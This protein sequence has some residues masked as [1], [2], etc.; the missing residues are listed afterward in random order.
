VS[1]YSRN[2]ASGHPYGKSHGSRYVG[3]NTDTKWQDYAGPRQDRPKD[4]MP[5]ALPEVYVPRMSKAKSQG[6]DLA[7]F[8]FG[9]V[10]EPEGP[11]AGSDAADSEGHAVR[12][13]V[14]VSD[15][16]VGV[17]DLVKDVYWYPDVDGDALL[18]GA[19]PSK[20][21]M[22]YFDLG[23]VVSRHVEIQ[24][25]NGLL[26]FDFAQFYAGPFRGRKFYFH[27]DWKRCVD[28]Y[29]DP[30]SRVNFWAAAQG[31]QVGTRQ[32]H[33]EA[34]RPG[35]SARFEVRFRRLPEKCVRLL[36]EALA[37]SS[38]IRHKLGGLKPFGFGS[39]CLR[40]SGLRLYRVQNGCLA[41]D[42]QREGE[43]R[44]ALGAE[45]S[46]FEAGVWSRAATWAWACDE[47]AFSCSDFRLRY[48]L[49]YP[50][51]IEKAPIFCYPAYLQDRGAGALKRGFAVPNAASV[52]GGSAAIGQHRPARIDDVLAYFDLPERDRNRKITQHLGLL[53]R[54]SRFFPAVCRRALRGEEELADMT[55]FIHWDAKGPTD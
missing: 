50:G 38:G 1:S 15:S 43:M 17:D 32:R 22:M 33:V 28:S 37:P 7:T 19:A 16:R 49:S 2:D 31:N 3:F 40:P 12:S 48:L 29:R 24:G 8:L 47:D 13:R 5:Q 35:A 11:E 4:E 14:V 10:L 52:L 26:K 23:D 27:Q 53:Q 9:A 25:R 55:D 21:S 34:M 44:E 54:R 36:V 6:I 39:I 41:R 51:E 30:Q 46:G 42:S 45:L 20:S 18:G